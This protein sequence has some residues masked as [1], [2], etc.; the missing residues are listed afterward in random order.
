MILT[1]I[2]FIINSHNLEKVGEKP[3]ELS[4]TTEIENEIVQQEMVWGLY[5]SFV[6]GIL[7]TI[8]ISWITTSM[9]I[10][11]ILELEEM[12]QEDWLVFRNKIAKLDEFLEVW[13]TKLNEVEYQLPI[14]FWLKNQIETYKVDL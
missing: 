6:E 3:V 1:F 4:L 14:I 10:N 7:K 11:F 12:G 13:M 8:L 9:Y 2:P 5:Q